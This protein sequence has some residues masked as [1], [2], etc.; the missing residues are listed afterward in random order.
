VLIALWS[1][2]GGSGT[3]VLA[4]A[5]AL[6]LARDGGACLA[7]LQGDQPAVL[8][9]DHDPST[10]LRDWL[11]VGVEAPTDA[12]DRLAVDAAPG[13]T[14]LPAGD[15]PISAADAEAGAALAVALMQYERPTVVDVGLPTAPAQEALLEVADASVTVLRGC[16]LALRR[17]ARMAATSGAA[18]AVLVEEPARALGAREIADVLGIP[19]LATVPIR[20]ST[21]RVIDAGVVR[22]R[23]PDAITR[24]AR[25]LLARLD[26]PAREGRV[27]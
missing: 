15:A 17:A 4:A 9:L 5:C 19:V 24:P 22:M 23:M 6:V 20:A 16:Y 27:A 18:G 8:G 12:L 2:K 7:D 13:L 11:S 3:S 21:A 26:R 10:G 25:H 14:L 1:P